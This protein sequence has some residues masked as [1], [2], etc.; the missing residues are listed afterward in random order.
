MLVFTISTILLYNYGVSSFDIFLIL[1]PAVILI[2]VYSYAR[3][4]FSDIL[5]YVV[6]DG[7]MAL[8]AILMLVPRI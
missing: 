3:H 8:S 7:L 1:L 5:Y 4:H 2:L 6:L